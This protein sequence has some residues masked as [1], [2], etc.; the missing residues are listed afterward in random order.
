[1]PRRADFGVPT[2]DALL[3]M[4]KILRFVVGSHG[5]AAIHCHSGLG[6]CS[7]ALHMTWLIVT[8][9][10]TGVLIAAYL[11]YSRGITGAEAV[12]VVRAHRRNA[13]QT[14]G[15]DCVLCCVDTAFFMSH[16]R[17][18]VARCGL[19]EQAGAGGCTVRRH[20]ALQC[21]AVLHVRT[22]MQC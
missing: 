13:I 19:I 6:M 15:Y 11:V 20:A 8:G 22:S 9:G 21:T 3:N 7:S 10:R 18:I 16:L 2:I 12:S 17:L 5:K 4:V 14:K 1:M